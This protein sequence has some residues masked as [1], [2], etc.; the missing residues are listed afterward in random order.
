MLHNF[1]HLDGKSQLAVAGVF[2]LLVCIG[3]LVLVYAS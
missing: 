2:F 1:R 3:V